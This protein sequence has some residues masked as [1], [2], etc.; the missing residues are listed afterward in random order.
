MIPLFQSNKKK[1]GKAVYTDQTKIIKL[2]IDCNS[3]THL[4]MANNNMLSLTKWTLKNVLSLQHL[5]LSGNRF[6]DL[7]GLQF[8][9]KHLETIILDDN[10]VILTPPL[11]PMSS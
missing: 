8:E 4:N 5:D 7:G 3:L 10:K 6:R 11:S 9:G 2:I 1:L